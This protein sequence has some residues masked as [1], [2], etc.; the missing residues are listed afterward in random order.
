MRFIMRRSWYLIAVTLALMFLAT[1]P[2]AAL[3]PPTV[4]FNLTGVGTG[5]NLG[6]VYTSPYTGNINGGSSMSVICDDFAD[7]SYV[8]ETWTA[9]QSSLSSVISGTYGTPDPYL[10]WLN[11]PTSTVSVDG[12]TLNQAKAYTVA[13]VL[14][15][16]ILTAPAGSQYQEDLSYSLWELFDYSDASAAL[17]G[18]VTDQTNALNY[19]NAAVVFAFNAAD[20]TQVQADV[21]ATTIYSYD[22]GATGSCGGPCTAPQEFIAVRMAEPASP[23]LLG[24]DLLAVGGLILFARRRLKLTQS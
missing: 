22:T 11:T 15:V 20:A 10:K 6:G 16:D 4:T 8:P 18:D 17:N 1:G 5:A 21:S 2:L 9:Y 12:M 7:D 24:L 14:A 13:A 3:P 23:A 19:L